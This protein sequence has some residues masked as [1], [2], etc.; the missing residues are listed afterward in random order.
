MRKF[1]YKREL[2]MPNGTMKMGDDCEWSGK[3]C[4]FLC[5]CYT[6]KTKK[7]CYII[8]DE[9]GGVFSTNNKNSI[10]FG[11]RE[12]LENQKQIVL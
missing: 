4:Q 5:A 8:M 7:W 11:E 10:L 6:F 2:A 12:Q 9:T 3:L 1:K